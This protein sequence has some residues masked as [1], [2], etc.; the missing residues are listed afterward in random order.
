[1]LL[2]KYPWKW[3][4]L[5]PAV[6]GL[7][8]TGLLAAR[9]TPVL[10]TRT[11]PAP[12]RVRLVSPVLAPAQLAAL[13]V[14]EA[15]HIPILMYHSIG[16]PAHR[17]A[18]YDSQG[19]NIAPQT[20][21][22]QLAL[23]YA[24]HWYPINMRDILT[25]HLNVPAGKTPV[26][27]TFDD[28]RGSQFHSL[29]NG[30]IDPNCAVGILEEFHTHHANWPLR[31]TFYV[32]PKSAWNPV[33]FWQPGL[34]TKKLQTLVADG[35]EVANHTTTHRPM[36]HLSGAELCWEMAECEEYVKA[37]APGATMDT[38]ALPGGAAPKNHALWNTLLEGRLG[39]ITYHNHCILMAWGGPSHAWV[40]KT[41]NPDRV[42][43]L[44]AG[45][46]WIE[47]A[48]HQ[49]TSGRLRPYVSDGNPNTVAVPRA[50]ASLVNLKR[51][52]DSR[53]V[54][55]GNGPKMPTLLAAAKRPARRT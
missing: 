52:G 22:R 8:L 42:T 16:A 23:M 6:A 35:F 29:P 28:A 51:L 43:R 24:A 1:M 37:R 46:G 10:P 15:G 47:H 38:M 14:D 32:L 5:L 36:T 34:E 53:L 20:F 30:K 55:Y 3:L 18:R 7:C 13:H 4:L 9:H 26:V 39:R 45:P 50:E 54:V 44:G 40:D 12:S 11:G 41:F 25:S 17:G 21:R 2:K 49:M 48:L 31:A 19:L 33:P 27:I